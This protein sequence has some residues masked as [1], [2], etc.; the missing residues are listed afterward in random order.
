MWS[1]KLLAMSLATFFPLHQDFQDANDLKGNPV[2]T[3][4]AQSISDHLFSSQMLP[5]SEVK[6]HEWNADGP[7]LEWVSLQIKKSVKSD[8]HLYVSIYIAIEDHMGDFMWID[9][10]TTK[11]KKRVTIWEYSRYQWTSKHSTL[12]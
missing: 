9:W 5:A 2:A 3:A 12:G 4:M 1:N 6:D 7:V 11:M 8:V 10:F